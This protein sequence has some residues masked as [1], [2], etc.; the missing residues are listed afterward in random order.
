MPKL[1]FFY[2]AMDAGK[3]TILIQFSYNYIKKN[4]KALIFLS[5]IVNKNGK[6]ASRI[7]LKKRAIIITDDFN[8]FKYLKNHKKKIQKI[9]IDEA[10]FLKK[11]H[12]FQLVSVVDILK[13]SVLTYGLR[14]DFRGK[15]FEG[16]KYLFTLADKIIEVKSLCECG[17]KAIMNAKIDKYKKK[18]LHG[19][20]VDLDKEKYISLC[21]Y[22]FYRLNEL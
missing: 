19:P 3:T 1:Y 11:K 12:I 17:R 5:N 22:H 20:Q 10:Q 9:L 21:R 13:I 14:T 4:I 7:G 18:I 15:L 2:S 6:I 8:I 16:S